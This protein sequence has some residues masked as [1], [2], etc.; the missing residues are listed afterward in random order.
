MD[1]GK[2]PGETD[3]SHK[4]FWNLKISFPVKG[5]SSLKFSLKNNFF[6]ELDGGTG[7]GEWQE[8]LELL[9]TS[10]NIGIK[11]PDLE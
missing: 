4:R 8:V 7:R 6:N 11:V 1:V 5:W 3:G 10:S 9:I 2:V